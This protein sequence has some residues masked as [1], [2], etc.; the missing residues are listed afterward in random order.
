MNTEHTGR[1]DAT[2][3]LREARSD[4]EWVECRSRIRSRWTPAVFGMLSTP[5]RPAVS[6][7]REAVVA[8][9]LRRFS[10]RAASFYL[11]RH[12]VVLMTRH[13]NGRHR[14]SPQRLAYNGRPSA[15]SYTRPR[16]L[17]VAPGALYPIF[18]AL[19]ALLLTSG[20]LHAAGYGL[21][22]LSIVRLHIH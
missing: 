11:P 17:H 4:G 22:I 14:Q 12:L 21:P 10:N 8:A 9:L 15:P 2:G 16:L 20:S 6:G 5:P 1:F 18:L 13:L 19:L 3:R 7:R